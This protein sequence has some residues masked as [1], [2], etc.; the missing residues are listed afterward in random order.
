[1]HYEGDSIGISGGVSYNNADAQDS[2]YYNLDSSGANKSVGY[3]SEGESQTSITKSAIN[4]SN[5]KVT[6]QKAQK[7]TGTGT[8]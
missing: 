8:E 6:D 7:A 3:G 1:M 5:I 2:K 4:T